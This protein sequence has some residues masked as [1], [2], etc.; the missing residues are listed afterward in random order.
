MGWKSI[1]RW[2][3]IEGV[4]TVPF[5]LARLGFEGMVHECNGIQPTFSIGFDNE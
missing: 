2:E 4:V 1:G 3:Q 5:S